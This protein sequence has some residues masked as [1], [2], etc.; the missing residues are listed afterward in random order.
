MGMR[1]VSTEELDCTTIVVGRGASESGHVVV[2]HNEDDAHRLAVRHHIVNAG[3]HPSATVLG[4]GTCMYREP[5]TPLVLPVPAE[6]LAYDWTE[7]AGQDF[8]D[9][10]L[11]SKGVSICCDSASG[12]REVQP[13]LSQ[14]SI[15]HLLPLLIAEQ[16]HSAR[17]GVLIAGQLVETWGYCDARIITIADHNEAWILQLPGGH[18]W[19][20]ERVPDSAVIVLPNYLI[21]RTVNLA[22]TGRVL[23]SSDLEAHAVERGWYDPSAGM[24][25]DFKNVYGPPDVN[26]S[27]MSTSRQQTGLFLLTGQEFPLDDLPFSC[28]PKHPVGIGDIAAC[29]RSVIPYG[30]DIQRALELPGSF[31]RNVTETTMRPISVW[32]TQDSS[33][34]EF[35]ES[36]PQARSVTAWRASGIPDELPYT[37]W[38]PLAMIQ[39]GSDYP[40]PYAIAD[41]D[42]LDAGSA[43]WTFR[44]FA[45]A[46]DNDY[47][48][49][50]QEVQAAIQPL[51]AR[52]R[53]TD[54]ILQSLPVGS[55][56]AEAAFAGLLAACGERFGMEAFSLCSR[57]LREWQTNAPPL[58]KQSS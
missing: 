45:T 35:K 19:L 21:S 16:A 27:P 58:P 41:P 26:T 15:G 39:A 14:G 42:H 12:T 8:G 29:L 38:Y 10:F 53:E 7:L 51:E 1:Y 32:T 30:H 9:S 28:V 54:R 44:L 6:S 3:E 4:D 37:P 33:I 11:N 24:P 55:E 56:Q 43:F 17:D 40:A 47:A 48:R 49:R 31:H 18:Q 34:T 13:E 52:A 50:M 5:H 25:F 57:L 22:D 36:T 23:A 20:A 46:V 2:G